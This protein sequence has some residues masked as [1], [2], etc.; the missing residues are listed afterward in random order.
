[1]RPDL[2]VFPGQMRQPYIHWLGKGE[3]SQEEWG[4]RSIAKTRP[5]VPTASQ[6]ISGAPPGGE[7]AGAYF[8]NPDLAWGSGFTLSPATIQATGLPIRPPV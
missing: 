5:T 2:L 8:P 4:R 1:M 6:L 7:G 3:Q